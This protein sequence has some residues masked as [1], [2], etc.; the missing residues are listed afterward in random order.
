MN[1][2]KQLFNVSTFPRTTTGVHTVNI[3]LECIALPAAYCQGY[4]NKGYVY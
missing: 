4:S 2:V 3:L 1:L